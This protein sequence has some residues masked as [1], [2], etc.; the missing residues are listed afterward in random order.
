MELLKKVGSLL[1]CGG[2]PSKEEPVQP[3]QQKQ[4]GQ[5]PSPIAEHPQQ[6][7]HEPSTALP[8]MSLDVP[9]NAMEEKPVHSVTEAP[10]ELQK[11]EE[12]R[13]GEEGKFKV[14]QWNV[15]AGELGTADSFPLVHSDCLEKSKRVELVKE[16]IK[17]FEADVLVLEELDFLEEIREALDAAGLEPRFLKKPENSD[18]TLIA[19]SR[20][21]KCLS[22]KETRLKGVDE[23]EGNRGFLQVELRHVETNKVLHVFGTHLKAKKPNHQVRL[24][25]VKQI[26]EAV[27][28]LKSQNQA[29]VLAGD[30]NA[31]PDE[32]T[33]QEVKRAG[34]SKT[35]MDDGAFTT[36]K[37]HDKGHVQQRQID[38]IF[39]FPTQ[40]AVKEAWQSHSHTFNEHYL[41]DETMPSDH[42]P[43]YAVFTFV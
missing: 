17:G 40:L 30:F 25:E 31:D 22:S 36:F 24:H 18:G 4:A 41:P 33:I 37:F 15:L 13:A 39:Y 3:T 27:N 26:L 12:A 2:E 19:F 7:N 34:L 10:G 43:I 6:A 20:H 11:E 42:F 16:L 14:V 9:T 28:T 35:I 21:F 23:A 5:A 8:T 29:I 32:E 1:G 38:Y